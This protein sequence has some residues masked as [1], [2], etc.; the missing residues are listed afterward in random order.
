M[1][2]PTPHPMP[3]QQ[4]IHLLLSRLISPTVFSAIQCLYACRQR[5]DVL[6]ETVFESFQ[7][8]SSQR[9]QLQV[10]CLREFHRDRQMN[11]AFSFEKLIADTHLLADNITLDR[12]FV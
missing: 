7:S 4:S 5:A 12:D 6:R 11:A 9:P 10:C 3:S 2:T 8:A 1:A